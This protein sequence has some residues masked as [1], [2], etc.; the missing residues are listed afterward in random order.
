MDSP[1]SSWGTFF[2]A[3]LRYR[4]TPDKFQTLVNAFQ[5]KNS[6]PSGRQ[7][8][9]VLLSEGKKSGLEDPRVPLFASE[10]LRMKLCSAADVLASLLP[11]TSED[12]VRNQALPE[13]EG[14]LR[15]S[16]EASILQM[17]TL[18]VGEG[19]LKTNEVIRAVLKSLVAWMTRYP[20]SRALGYLIYATLSSPLAHAAISHPSMKGHQSS[21]YKRYCV[22][23]LMLTRNKNLLWPLSFRARRTA[24]TNGSAACNRFGFLAETV[25]HPR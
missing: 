16:I 10:L 22:G 6:T 11:P 18:E 9:R 5:F 17:M 1:L 15:P 23:M 8:I 12:S 20:S 2:N 25:R 13:M 21:A 24:L 4:L 19:L 14:I 7:L 3:C